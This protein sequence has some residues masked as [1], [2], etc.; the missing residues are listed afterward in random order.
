MK[1][2]LGILLTFAAIIAFA[3]TACKKDD[4]D[5]KKNPFSNLN[6]TK[7]TEIKVTIPRIEKS[8]TQN[9]GIIVYISVTDQDGEVLSNFNQ[10]NFLL[11]HLCEGA[12]T[13]K[14]ERL[15]I[16]PVDQTRSDVATAITMDYSGSMSNQRYSEYGKRCKTIYQ[17]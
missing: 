15:V 3:L 2:S 11:S 5:P 9:K 13:I 17:A 1:K 8:Q 7:T 14:V 10:Y 6:D 4:D 12:D 16:T